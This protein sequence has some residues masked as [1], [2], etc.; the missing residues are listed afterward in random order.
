MFNYR[1]IVT[2]HS[3]KIHTLI[4]QPL[5]EFRFAY[6]SYLYLYAI[7]PVI[8]L[9]F[10]LWVYRKRKTLNRFGQ[11]QII[12]PLFEKTSTTKPLTKFILSVVALSFLI[13]AV[14]GPQLGSKLTEVKRKGIDIIICLDVSNSMNAED[15]KPSRLERSKQAISKLIDNLQGDRIGLIVFAGQAYTQ[16]PITTDYGAAKLFLTSINSDMVPTQ[17]TAIGAAIDLA[18]E[19]FG[20]SIKKHNAAIIVITDGE[21]HEDDAIEAAKNA[22]D[23]GITIHTVGMGLPQGGPIPITN[24]G[25]RVGYL[26][27][28][29]GQT[30]I[31]KLDENNLMQI[32]SAGNGKFVRATNSD[33]GLSL[34]MNDIAKMDKK[35]FSSKLFTDYEDQFQWCI[36]IALILLV[37][38]FLISDRKTKWIQQLNLFSDDKRKTA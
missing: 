18:I 22:I 25:V 37:I 28:E 8:I 10:I 14:C 16:L 13:L 36:A 29:N 2:I 20:D 4:N 19:S 9:L 12:K 33:D 31:T 23:K 6:E 3:I 17:G 32:A 34:I 5:K 27:D 7:V 11:S 21:N 1:A 15:I 26:Q 30:V 24:N 35:E 38:E